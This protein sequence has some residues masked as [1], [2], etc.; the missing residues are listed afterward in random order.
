MKRQPRLQFTDAELSPKL[1]RHV[2]RAERAADKAER[3]R[4]KIP[5]D[6][7]KLKR[8]MIEQ[9]FA[10]VRKGKKHLYF[11]DVDRPKPPSK[12]SHAVQ[13]APLNAASVQAHRKIWEAEQ[14]N[15][16]LESA[17]RLEEA[18]EG[19]VRL[20]AYSYRAQKLRPYREAA[21]AERQLEKAN[22]NALYQKHLHDNPQLASNPLSRWQQKRA[23]QK[24]YAASVKSGQT[25]AATME[26]TARAAKKA[27]E[28][29]KDTANFIIRHK[30]GIGIILGLLACVSLLLNCMASCS[31]LLEGG[32]SALGGSTYPCRDEDML[33]AEAAY[34]GMEAAL[35]NELDNYASLHPGYDEY[36]FDLDEISHDPY[37]LVSILTAYHRGEWT[38]AEVQGTLEMLFDQQ[39]ILT[40]EVVVE[41]RYRTE[42]DTWTDEDGNSHTDTYQVPYDYYI[43][44]VTLENKNL[45]HL[46]VYFMSEEQMSRYAIYMSTVGN[47][48]DLFPDSPYVDRYITNPPQGYEVPGEYLDDETFAAM[49]SEAQKYIGYPYVWG[50]SSPATSFDCS[51]YLSWVINHSGWNVG[52][53]TAQGLYN[54]CTPVSSPRP[55][56]LVFFKGTYNTSGVSH[57]GIYVGD[58]RMLHCGDPIGYANLNTNYWQSHL[59]AYGRLP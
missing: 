19:G 45:S 57:C 53:Q 5:K 23:I 18:A 26:N 38:L 35:Q 36:N 30:K 49:L 25:A 37:V 7:K 6:R 43:C 1:K 12:L 59:Y 42:T 31:V 58:G 56:D 52:R 20:A 32:L 17:H 21:R 39:Y 16:G 3:A 41:V 47:R 27:A 15:T 9:Q 46:P 13:S 44:Y 14:D 51:G 50:G 4:E 8:R 33:G 24:Q 34:A 22:V 48:P 40:E 10:K 28:K 29:S 2:R 54:L 55:G 11:E